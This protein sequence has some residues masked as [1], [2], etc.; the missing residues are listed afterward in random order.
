MFQFVSTTGTRSLDNI[1]LDSRTRTDAYYCRTSQ[2]NCNSDQK[3]LLS[4]TLQYSTRIKFLHRKR[5][6]IINYHITL[7]FLTLSL[8]SFPLQFKYLNINVNFSC[9]KESLDIFDN[10]AEQNS[11]KNNV[12]C[13]HDINGKGRQYFATI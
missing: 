5:I 8:L 7:I 2:G 11:N 12:Y 3:F 4:L 1:I 13:T 9:T 10:F 6:I